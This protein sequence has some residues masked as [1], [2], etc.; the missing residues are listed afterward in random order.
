MQLLV[1]EDKIRELETL[2]AERDR[3]IADLTVKLDKFQ[4]EMFFLTLVLF[5]NNGNPI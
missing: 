3:M 1:K 5:F 4:V 2:L